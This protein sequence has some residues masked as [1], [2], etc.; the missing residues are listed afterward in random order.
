MSRHY[1]HIRPQ[2][3]VFVSLSMSPWLN[4]VTL[5]TLAGSHDSSE[6][7]KVDGSKPGSYDPSTLGLQGWVCT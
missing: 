1:Q 7:A 6:G 5:P 4:I 3:D 2:V